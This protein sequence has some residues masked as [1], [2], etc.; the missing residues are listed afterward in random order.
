MNVEKPIIW[1]KVNDRGN[2]CRGKNAGN[3]CDMIKMAARDVTVT[4]IQIKP[5]LRPTKIML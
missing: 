3:S 2:E 4:M 5:D 1:K